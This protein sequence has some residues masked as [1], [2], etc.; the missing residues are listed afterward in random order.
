MSILP[1]DFKF[2]DAH[3]HFFPPKVFKSVWNFFERPDEEGI[4]TQ[5]P[6]KYKLDTEERIKFL[7]EHHVKA[8]TT[9]NY[10][11]KAGMAEFLNEW[12]HDFAKRHQNA[13]PFGTVWPG[14]ENR[15]E[16]LRKIFDEYD[17]MGI[18]IQLLVQNFYPDDE[19]MKLVYDLIHDRGK[20]ICFHAG[21][22]PYR[23]KYVGYKNFKKFLDK[24]PDMN[25]IIAHMGGFEYKKFMGLLDTH[26]N[27]YLDTTMI[28]IPNNIFSER[29]SKRP[30]EEDLITYQDRIL[31]GSDFP[32]IPYDYQYS[33]A[34]LLEMDL[35]KNVHKKIF[36]NNAK[37]IFDIK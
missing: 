32:N 9:Y 33:R 26:E 12:T 16:Y 20:W 13:I 22:A 37:R 14:D 17:F 25:L 21:T 24:Y 19:R 5:W 10:A 11:H 18:K 1:D 34:G 27:L 3:C 28:Y 4:A 15:L 8:F 23:N 7:E 35:P 30:K 36:N 6:V 29:K 2:I 31:Y